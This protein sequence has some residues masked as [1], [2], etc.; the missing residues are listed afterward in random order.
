MVDIITAKTAGFCFGVKKAVDKAF[1]L[2]DPK[3]QVYTYGP[4][5]HNDEVI[6]SLSEKGVRL[7]E[8]EEELRRIENGTVILRSHGVP[9]AVIDLLEER[10]IDYVDVTCPFVKRIHDIVYKESEDKQIVIAGNP[11]HP[12]VEGIMG[13]CKTPADVISAEEEAL[14]YEPA[15]GRDVCLVAQTTFNYKKFE[16]ILEIFEKKSYYV[17]I[18]NTIC[19]AT[20]NHQTEARSIAEGV[21]A[22]IVIGDKKSSNSRKLYEICSEVC[23]KTEFIQTVDELKLIQDGSIATVGITAGASTPNY[24]IEE[25]QNYVRRE[26]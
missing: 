1:E 25:V 22:M 6:R 8:S 26:F 13:W 10:G 23:P 16:K 2:A 5:I 11:A 12:E 9:K 18:V 4:V 24:I 3:K 15:G 14:A 17:S 19:N 20:A 21:D 7:I